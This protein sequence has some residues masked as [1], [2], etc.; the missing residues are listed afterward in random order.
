MNGERGTLEP[1]PLRATDH[2]LE[3]MAARHVTPEEAV[4]VVEHPEVTWTERNGYTVHQRGDIAVVAD[5]RESLVITV[6]YRRGEDWV[7]DDGR[8]SGRVISKKRKSRILALA[9]KARQQGPVVI[10]R[11]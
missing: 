8:P 6:L 5:L 11:P 9:K 1:A 2:A 3:K 4:A 10:R 7:D